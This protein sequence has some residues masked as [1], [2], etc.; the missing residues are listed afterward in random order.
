MRRVLFDLAGDDRW[1]L[2]PFDKDLL[3]VDLE[4]VRA[5]YDGR[6]ELPLIVDARGQYDAGLA[7]LGYLRGVPH[8]ELILVTDREAPKEHSAA[9]AA[10]ATRIYVLR[11]GQELAPA[12]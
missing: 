6:A 11:L 8:R 1:H 12:A 4:N 7:L 9:Y 10:G 3:R 5:L 2:K